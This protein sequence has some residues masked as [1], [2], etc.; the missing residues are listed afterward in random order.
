MKTENEKDVVITDRL[1]RTF[2]RL[3]LAI[4]TYGFTMRSLLNDH[5]KKTSYSDL[6]KG[7]ACRALLE[8]VEDEKK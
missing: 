8:V 5:I 7:S 4:T 2:I 6:N 1:Y 3:N